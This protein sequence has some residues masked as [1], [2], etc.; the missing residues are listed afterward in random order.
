[1]TTGT[2]A[3]IPREYSQAVITAIAGVYENIGN[4]IPFLMNNFDAISE[5]QGSQRLIA[6][7]IR[8][9]C[10]LHSTSTESSIVNNYFSSASVTHLNNYINLYFVQINTFVTMNRS[11][12]TDPADLTIIDNALVTLRN[13]IAWMEAFGNPM[14]TWFNNNKNN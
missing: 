10:N 2:T 3:E 8:D 14:N 7:A 6:N 13:N 1:M 5:Y 11:K 9:L 4:M 12:F